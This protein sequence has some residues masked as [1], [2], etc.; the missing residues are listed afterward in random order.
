MT[1]RQE[2]LKEAKTLGI[3][4]TNRMTNDQ[5]QAVITAM[6][7]HTPTEEMPAN[8]PISGMA[9]TVIPDK[10]ATKISPV[11]AKGDKEIQPEPKA[12]SVLFKANSNCQQN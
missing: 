6:E 12:T 3:K 9:A 7:M 2:L 10:P 1:K 4:E 8:K 11:L 5:I